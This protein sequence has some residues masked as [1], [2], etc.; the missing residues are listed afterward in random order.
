MQTI[1]VTGENVEEAIAKGLAELGVGPSDIIYEVL[2]EPSRG[3]FG[4]GARLARVRLQVIGGR[5]AA[6]P[7]PAYTPDDDDDN[8]DMDEGQVTEEI[9]AAIN[10]VFCFGFT[11]QD[12]AQLATRPRSIGICHSDNGFTISFVEAP[13][14]VVNA[15][16]EEWTQ[17]LSRTHVA[18]GERHA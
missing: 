9:R 7:E 12:P 8:V 2:E 5:A 1:E 6:P 14:P 3:M 18:A 4:L 16:M 15:L 17:S 11:L 10:L 13:M